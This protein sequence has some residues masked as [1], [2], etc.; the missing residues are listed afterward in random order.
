MATPTVHPTT[1]RLYAELPEFY[2]R[3][4]LDDGGPDGAPL[5]RFLSL[6]GDQ[7]GDLDD[8]V[9]RLDPDTGAGSELL[10]AD[11]ADAGWLRWLGQL[12]GVRVPVGLS[13][14]EQRIAVGGAVSGWRAGTRAA[15]ET[16]ARS[17]LTDP[18]GVVTV[19]PHSGGNPYVIGVSVDP[20]YAPPDLDD[21]VAAIEEARARPA[22]IRLIID[23][24]AATWAT[25]ET[26]RGTWGGFEAATMWVRLEGTN[27][28]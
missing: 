6:V 24:Y 22:G 18:S 11:R 28:P 20:E 16:A 13:E 17:A 21:V 27:P 8:L 1:A 9:D 19:R 2:R 3:E 5:L 10:D 4:D 7:L 14:V 26:V 25:L 15:L 23:L 12:I